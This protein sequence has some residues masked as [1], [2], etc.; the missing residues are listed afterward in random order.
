MAEEK[1][2]FALR[3]EP[4]TRELVKQ[5]YE[6]DNCR[7]QNEFIEKAIRFYAG[8]LSAANGTDYL[9]E[10]LVSM[11]QGSLQDTENRIARLLFKLSVETSMMMNVL[12]AGIEINDDELRRLRGKCVN[13]VKRTNGRLSFDEAVKYQR[14]TE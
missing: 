14:H 2:K 11:L 5:L 7:S 4:E 8:Y 12:A 13:D 3:L 6:Q 1:V 10:V 9:A